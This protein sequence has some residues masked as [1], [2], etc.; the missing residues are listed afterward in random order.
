MPEEELPHA[1]VGAG[2]ALQEEYRQRREVLA[3]ELEHLNL[4]HIF[5]STF[6]LKNGGI[7]DQTSQISVL[8]PC[9][10]IS[11]FSLSLSLFLFSLLILSLICFAL[12]SDNDSIH[13]VRTSW[14]RYSRSSSSE[15]RSRQRTAKSRTLWS[16]NFASSSSSAT[17]G[18]IVGQFESSRYISRT[19]EE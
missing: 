2:G 15:R 6:L 13:R 5:R 18:S 7:T 17:T 19:C 11:R 10:Q 9:C 8:I 3:L 4:R 1:A 14:R 16:G 12:K